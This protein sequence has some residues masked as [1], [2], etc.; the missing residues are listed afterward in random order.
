MARL[1]WIVTSLVLA[2]VVHVGYLLVAPS[3][4]IQRSLG[5]LVAET[6]VNRFFILGARDQAR[7][8]PAFPPQHIFGACA[9]DLRDTKIALITGRTNTRRKAGFC[10]APACNQMKPMVTTPTTC[11]ATSMGRRPSV[12]PGRSISVRAT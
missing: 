8:F 9:F 2:I 3:Y 6:G 1:Y 4:A 5:A 11:N 10:S 7:L 12:L